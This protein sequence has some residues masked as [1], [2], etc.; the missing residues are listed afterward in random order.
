MNREKLEMLARAKL[1]QKK[2]ECEKSFYSFLVYF[3]DV[4]IA[5]PIVENW[6]LK[7]LCDELQKA[8]EKVL[9]GVPQKD[10]IVNIPP[11]TTKSTICSVVLPAWA[12]VAAPHLKFITGSYSAVLANG[13]AV[14]SRDIL[15]S[16]KFNRLWPEHIVFKEDMDTK[17]E[18]WNTK[19]GGRRTC[20]TDGTITGFH[21]HIILIDDPLNPKMA[22]SE[23]K[24]KTANDWLDSTLSTRKIDKKSTLTVLIMQRLADDDCTGHLLAKKGKPINHICIPGELKTMDNVRPV[25]LKKFY[26]NGVM[27]SGRMGPDVLES[28][29]IDLGGKGYAGQILQH[30]AAAEGT[31][32]KREWWKWYHEL[33]QTPVIR[34]VQSW[35][36]AFVK[37][38]E[39]AE[40][41]MVAGS[42][43][44]TGLYLTNV[45][46]K[47][48]EFPQLDAQIRI[49][50]ARQPAPHAV[51]I[52]NKASGISEIQV[53][54]QQTQIPVIP[55]QPEGDKISRAHST[56]PFVEAGN[57]WLPYDAPWVAEFVEIMA[58]FPDIKL[59]DVPDAFTQ[60]ISWL[61]LQPLGKPMIKSRRVKHRNRG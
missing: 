41:G 42:Q 21:A 58:G 54:K 13:M 48:L 5:E 60:L 25:E 34:R 15:K 17:T 55:I 31:I 39:G 7:F 18:Y 47:G 57:V 52:E 6:H 36:T 33:P 19:T 8:V 45:F 43:Y 59:K 30:P 22:A 23:V 3:W 4:I 27:D 40:N 14:K 24:K 38:K 49:E 2:R 29:R 12:W 50:A 26:K 56:T 32:F 61:I 20:S 1:E 35:D 44:E 53:L 9:A 37:G 51:L 46:H 11:G 10:I 16:D 28:L